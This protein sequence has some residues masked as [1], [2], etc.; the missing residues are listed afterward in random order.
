MQPI[1]LSKNKKAIECSDD[2]G[3]REAVYVGC[4]LMKDNQRF[5]GLLSHFC[6]D[7]ILLFF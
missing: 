4:R 6:L 1:S 5:K 7:I 3:H 2:S